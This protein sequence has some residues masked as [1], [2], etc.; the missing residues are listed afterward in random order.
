M[1]SARK[2]F[3]KRVDIVVE[4]GAEELFPEVLYKALSP[5]GIWIEEKGND[6]VIKCYPDNVDAF[7]HILQTSKMETKDTLVVD[8]P[9]QDYAEMTKKYFRPIQ[10]EG[11]TILAPWNK[12]KR[13]GI[14]ILIEPG[15]AFG[16]GRHE[17]TRIMVKLMGG[18]DMKDKSILDIGCGS[19]ILSLYATVLGAQKVVA[20]D[21][22]EDTVLSAH[23]NIDLNNVSNIALTCSDLQQVRG[24]YDI[25]LANIDIRTFKATSAHVMTLV[26][27]S[28]YLVVSGILGRDRKE[29]LSL[30]NSFSLIRME[31]KNAWRGFVLQKKNA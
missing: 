28:G 6:A 11:I 7:L 17:S 25:V 30:F 1:T 13:K 21:N 29:L 5:G 9:E 14:R 22:D 15:M 3:K 24:A 10:V 4:K 19:A 26:K 27:E 2:G 31:Q 23:K 20:V 8:E 16:T 12:T 18:M